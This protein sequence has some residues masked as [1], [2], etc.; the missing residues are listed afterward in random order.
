MIRI[1]GN[2]SK[3]QASARGRT[4]SNVHQRD[5]FS[6]NERLKGAMKTT[7]PRWIF[8]GIAAAAPATQP[9]KTQAVKFLRRNLQN[10]IGK[11]VIVI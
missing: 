6:E 5:A 8:S 10:L 11:T 2:A 4:A 3:I 9:I 7:S 1:F